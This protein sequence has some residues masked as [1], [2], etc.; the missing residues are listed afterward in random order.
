MLLS[1]HYNI[2]WLLLIPFA[3]CSCLLFRGWELN[4][5]NWQWHIIWPEYIQQS[6]YTTS[7]HM[8]PPTFSTGLWC[9]VSGTQLST[10][11]DICFSLKPHFKKYILFKKRKMLHSSWRII[12]VDICLQGSM[13][14]TLISIQFE[15]A[16]SFKMANE[17][18]LSTTL[19]ILNK[20]QHTCRAA[21][22]PFTFR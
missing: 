19:W 13:R 5:Q 10:S 16:E 8:S 1:L 15:I 14:K 7:V 2:L 3:F 9:V 18:Y 22:H 6:T 21:P 11:L 4:T 12:T 17:R 20:C